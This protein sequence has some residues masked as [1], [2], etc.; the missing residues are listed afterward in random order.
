MKK[1]ER[2]IVKVQVSLFTS[3]QVPMML[4]YNEDQSYMQEFPADKEIVEEMNGEPKVFMWAHI[5]D[6][7]IL[8]LEDLAP[9]QSW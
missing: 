1:N 4:V 5:G 3:G 7:D 2:F 9:W 6:D 8:N